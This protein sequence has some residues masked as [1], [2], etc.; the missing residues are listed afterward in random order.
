MVAG[1]VGVH[2][3]AVEVEELLLHAQAGRSLSYR[4]EEEEGEGLC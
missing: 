3:Q 2:A 1:L 4:E